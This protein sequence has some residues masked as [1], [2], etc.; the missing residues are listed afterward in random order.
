MIRP[1]LAV[2]VSAQSV[3]AGNVGSDRDGT[4]AGRAFRPRSALARVP[5][6]RTC[7]QAGIARPH[8]GCTRWH[9]PTLFFPLFFI[10][11][12]RFYNLLVLTIAQPLSFWCR[13]ATPAPVATLAAQM[14]L[15]HIARG[16]RRTPDATA[17][18]CGLP[19]RL[20][21]VHD[22]AYLP[23]Y[24]PAGAGV[25]LAGVTFRSR[26]T[27]E[28]WGSAAAATEYVAHV[29][30]GTDA[31]RGGSGRV[32]HRVSV[33]KAV[34]RWG[35]HMACTPRGLSPEYCACSNDE[36]DGDGST[37]DSMDERRRKAAVEN[38][39]AANTVTRGGQSWIFVDG[40][41]DVTIPQELCQGD[42]QGSTT[43]SPCVDV[44]VDGGGGGGG[45][46]PNTSESWLWR[47]MPAAEE[48]RRR[49]DEAEAAEAP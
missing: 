43:W 10:A 5:A 48:L 23:S 44:D 35:K 3:L 30:V 16:F 19:V 24:A 26:F 14:M 33:I 13:H 46:L 34:S 15:A 22:A 40:V 27:V 32:Y 31:A 29:V 49:L 20:A 21:G 9:A 18:L 17:A 28:H 7:A 1:P 42:L 38:A 2:V 39:A 25:G 36:H 8:C 41:Y 11:I 47:M 6:G 37:L 4:C 45:E 12:A